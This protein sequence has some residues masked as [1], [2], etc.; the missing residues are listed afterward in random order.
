MMTLDSASNN[1]IEFY[2]LPPGSTSTLQPADVY[3]NRT[4]KNFIRRASDWIRWKKP[5]YTL[6]IRKKYFE[7]A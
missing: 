6:A 3:Y 1:S 7:L 2:V 5:E 4:F